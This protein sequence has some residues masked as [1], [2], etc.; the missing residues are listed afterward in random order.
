MLEIVGAFVA[1]NDFDARHGVVGNLQIISLFWFSEGEFLTRN[2]M[3]WSH[4][5]KNPF[6]HCW[7]VLL[8][9]L[10]LE[11]FHYWLDRRALKVILYIVEQPML[12]SPVPNI[13]S[14]E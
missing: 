5:C 12:S 11:Q 13:H 10:D 14:R 3:Y 4:V 7:F 6:I 8:V 2:A 9:T 1:R